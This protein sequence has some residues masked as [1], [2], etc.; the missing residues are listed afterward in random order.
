LQVPSIPHSNLIMCEGT[1][2]TARYQWRGSAQNAISLTARPKYLVP[3]SLHISIAPGL[4]ASLSISPNGKQQC[5]YTPL[6]SLSA[7]AYLSITFTLSVGCSGPLYPHR[8]CSIRNSTPSPTNGSLITTLIRPT[9]NSGSSLLEWRWS[10]TLDLNILV[11]LEPS[12]SPTETI[13]VWSDTWRG[14]ARANGWPNP[15]SGTTP[16]AEPTTASS[17]ETHNSWQLPSDLSPAL[18]G[19]KSK[20]TSSPKPEPK[21]SDNTVI[22]S[23]RTERR[24]SWDP[25]PYPSLLPP[26]S[27]LNRLPRAPKKV[28]FDPIPKIHLIPSCL[29]Q[30]PEKIT[31]RKL[32]LNTL[33]LF[34]TIQKSPETQK[35]ILSISAT[36]NHT[37]YG[38]PPTTSQLPPCLSRAQLLLPSTLFSS[39]DTL[40]NGL[41]EGTPYGTSDIQKSPPPLPKNPL[42]P[43]PPMKPYPLPPWSLHRMPN[44]PPPLMT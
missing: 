21:S 19:E 25:P 38:L 2:T 27:P 34:N 30:K 8:L 5:I 37:N 23:I 3:I 17:A 9:S 35:R 36:T 41:E 13:T 15:A 20:P 28:H 40:P 18:N 33:P 7:T 4:R 6:V 31:P 29:D 42:L 32:P 44:L 12:T 26:L 43:L 22:P 24:S 10:P 39:T 11:E 16:S 14:L 1:S